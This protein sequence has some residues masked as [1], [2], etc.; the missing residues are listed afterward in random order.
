MAEDEDC[1][2]LVPVF[3]TRFISELSDKRESQKINNQ[4]I[5]IEP[6]VFFDLNQKS[7]LLLTTLTIN[8]T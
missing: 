8:S 2:S 4:N 1:L 3:Y 5:H 6:S 7:G